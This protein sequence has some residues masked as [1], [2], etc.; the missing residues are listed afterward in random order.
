MKNKF[1]LVLVF[2]CSLASLVFF[3]FRNKK[4]DFYLYN[5]LENKK[6]KIDPETDFIILP[7]DLEKTN[8]PMFYTQNYILRGY[9]DKY[10]NNLK[11]IEIKAE[12]LNRNQYRNQ[13]AQINQNTIVVCWPS[14]LFDQV[15][16]I[17]IPTHSLTFL[18]DDPT[19]TLRVKEEKLL[20]EYDLKS[21]NQHNY[22]I[23]QLEEPI[24]S[25]ENY[26]NIIKKLII[27]MDQC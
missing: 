21:L 26:I 15:K 27:L 24:N 4:T 14:T 20:N 8:D 22:I 5:Q 11:E 19:D 18:I 2:L 6:E 23:M 25:S 9:L 13:R 17:N 12:I 1:F 7:E 3:Y 16:K 10:D